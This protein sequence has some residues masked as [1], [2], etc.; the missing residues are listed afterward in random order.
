MN[1]IAKNITAQCSVSVPLSKINNKLTPILVNT[2]I[3]S[4]KESDF[5]NKSR[6]IF[7]NIGLKYKA[8]VIKAIKA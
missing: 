3:I 6:P 1:K 4:G 8:D 5:F 7:I 2:K